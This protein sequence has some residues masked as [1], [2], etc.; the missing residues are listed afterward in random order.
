MEA[1][2]PHLIFIINLIQAGSV[3]EGL[4]LLALL[5]FMLLL[6]AMFSGSEVAFFSLNRQQVEELEEDDNQSGVAS[7]LLLKNHPRRLLAL[8]LICNTFVNIAIAILVERILSVYFP[9]TGFHDFATFLVSWR[10]LSWLDPAQL[11][12]LMYF[13]VAVIGATTLILLFG[14][15]TP[16]IYGQFNSIKLARFIARPLRVLD[17]LMRPFTIILESLTTSVER[18]II[19]KKLN[20][21]TTS[22]EDL[23]AAIDL[24]VS[25][26]QESGKQVDMLK[27]I[28]K[29]NDVT[30][31]QVM[32][33]RTEVYAVDKEENYKDVIQVIRDSGFSRLPIFQNDLDHICGILYAKDL[34][35]HLEEGADF[36]WQQLIRTSLH[37]VPESRKINE[38][39]NDLQE[40]HLHMAFVVD[41]YGGL[42]G[43]VTLEDIMEEIVGEIKDEFDDQHELNFTKLDL[44]NYLFDGK[45]LI[46]DM[47]RV[48]GIDIYLFEDVRGNAD[49]IAGLLLENLG[50]MPKKDQEIQI[51][52]CLF[53]VVAVSKKRI[54]QIKVTI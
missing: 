40:K 39:L 9:V 16:K 30:A 19:E 13:M 18:K 53:K 42:S 32:T 48:L 54:E 37:F 35:G 31:K 50:E 34:I 38:L 1:E 45:T 22:R 11:G 49:S 47:C 43:L 3:F 46:N 24:A 23:D 17:Y 25:H 52:A 44:H 10:P 8:L 27:G 33:A 15:V 28:I 5:V 26:E 20:V 29:F 4:G 36:E 14:E 51:G 12:N 6:S 21:Q 2:P 7:L 41:E